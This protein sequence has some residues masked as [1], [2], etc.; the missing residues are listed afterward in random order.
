M[1][2]LLARANYQT[3]Q[4]TN[5]PVQPGRIIS[6]LRPFAELREEDCRDGVNG[7]YSFVRLRQA[8]RAVS[9]PWQRPLSG[10]LLPWRSAWIVP[11]NPS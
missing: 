11:V 2:C 1:V 9:Q 6:Q 7:R 10:A 3:N 4:P 5:K 8:W